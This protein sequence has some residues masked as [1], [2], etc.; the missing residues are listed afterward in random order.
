VRCADLRK[1]RS[2]LS[3]SEQVMPGVTTTIVERFPL[4]DDPE[5]TACPRWCDEEDHLARAAGDRPRRRQRG[6]SRAT[7]AC[8]G[9]GWRRPTPRLATTARAGST[10]AGDQDLT[11]AQ[12]REYAALILRACK[13]AE[14]IGGA[15]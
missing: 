6:A 7:G 1:R 12:A 15:A 3:E 13:L 10:P 14:Q 2:P 8:R 4:P 11:P 9:R 5:P